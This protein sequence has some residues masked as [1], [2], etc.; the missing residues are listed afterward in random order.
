M[1]GGGGSLKDILIR[2]AGGHRGAY[3]LH[4]FDP[5]VGGHNSPLNRRRKRMRAGECAI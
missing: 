5:F 2:G 3:T 4:V 1:I